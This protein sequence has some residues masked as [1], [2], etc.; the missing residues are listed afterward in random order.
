MLSHW[1]MVGED[2]S[3]L[4]CCVLILGHVGHFAHSLIVCQRGAL[5]VARLHRGCR[6]RASHRSP[7]CARV[8]G[9]DRLGSQFLLRLASQSA[10][11]LARLPSLFGST[12]KRANCAGA[13]IDLDKI[14]DAAKAL[15]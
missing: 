14:S 1:K 9:I 3:P 6:S 11:Q 10:S 2:M 7:V 5:C 15:M 8:R 12:P 13:Q 4:V